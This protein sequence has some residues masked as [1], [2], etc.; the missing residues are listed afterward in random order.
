M[1][2]AQI[3]AAILARPEEIT[4]SPTGSKKEVVSLQDFPGVGV[5]IKGAAPC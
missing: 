1:N 5:R 4:T 3:T 2:K